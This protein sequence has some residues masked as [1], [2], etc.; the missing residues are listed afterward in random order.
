ML[1][2]ESGT[3][4]RKHLLHCSE[5]DLC[6]GQRDKVFKTDFEVHLR[7]HPQSGGGPPEA[8]QDTRN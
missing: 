4:T 1:G 7:M 5:A 6:E 2:P 3:D 8:R